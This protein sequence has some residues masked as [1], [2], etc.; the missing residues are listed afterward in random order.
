[1]TIRRH[2]S[3]AT[4]VVDAGTDGGRGN[5]IALYDP[6]RKQ[7]YSYFHLLGP[8]EAGVGEKL[9][10]GEKVGEVGCTGSCSGDHLHFEVLDGK[11]PYG[12]PRDPMPL[13]AK[14]E[15]A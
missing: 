10:P 4:V 3:P 14:W 8:A 2:V 12:T 7:T 13:L 9:K 6:K 15:R 11:G 5:W 1:M